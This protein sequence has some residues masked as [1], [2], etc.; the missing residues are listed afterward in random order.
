VVSIAILTPT[1]ERPQQFAAMLAAIRATSADHVEVYVG[2]DED[3]ASP[4]EFEDCI[5]CRGPRQQLAGWTNTLLP[6]ALEDGHEIIGSLGDDHR[7]RTAGWDLRVRMAFD[8]L[9]MGPRVYN[10]GIVGPGLRHGFAPIMGKGLVYTRDGLQDERLPTAPFWSADIL[11][12]LGWF[13]P[14]VLRHL[15]ADDFW[16]RFASHIGRCTYLPDVLIEHLH[17]SATGAEP[18]AINV[19][20]DSH[21]G[22]DRA[23]FEAFVASD[24]YWGC[25]ERVKAIL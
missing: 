5:V 15:Y 11:R 19:E 9:E 20:N 8:R 18:D 4:Y 22:E 1:R 17:P 10:L 2:V 24:Q 13:F 7:P 3:D 16:L 23:A 14:L 21:Y 6:V 12:E 25:V